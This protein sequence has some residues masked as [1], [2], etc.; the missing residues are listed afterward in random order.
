ML[1]RDLSRVILNKYSVNIE[2]GGR[3]FNIKMPSI[4]RLAELY[5]HW[6]VIEETED[7]TDIIKYREA[8][9][10]GFKVLISPK[11]Y[12]A[13]KVN[14][15]LK[16]ATLEE[17]MNAYIECSKITNGDYFFQIASSIS[18]AKKLIAKQRL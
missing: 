12:N 11:W 6:G 10:S 16:K 5:E 4:T 9:L 7:I 3:W 15:S 13:R 1:Q 8:L 14:N 2:L 18:N 17:I